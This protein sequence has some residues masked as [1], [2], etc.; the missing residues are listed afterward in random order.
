M[1][2]ETAM[3]MLTMVVLEVT[4]ITVKIMCRTSDDKP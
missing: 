3:I 1:M 2:M 4:R